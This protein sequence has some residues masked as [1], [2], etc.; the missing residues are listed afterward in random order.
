MMNGEIA[1]IGRVYGGDGRD[2]CSPRLTEKSEESGC[3]RVA[4]PKENRAKIPKIDVFKF[5]QNAPQ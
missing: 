5:R 3:D 1:R 2:N 4:S